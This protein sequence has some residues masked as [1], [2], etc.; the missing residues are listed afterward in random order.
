[1]IPIVD[2]ALE[3]YCRRHSRTPDPRVEQVMLSVRDGMMLIRK[4]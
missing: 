2:P 3:E 1:M 4:R